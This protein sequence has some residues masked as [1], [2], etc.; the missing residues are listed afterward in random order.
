MRLG[1]RRALAAGLA[2]LL[3]GCGGTRGPAAAA[4][5]TTGRRARVPSPKVASQ[6]LLSDEILWDLGP[7]VR[8]HVVAV[9]ALADDP[10]YADRPGLWPP[11][12]PRV[13]TGSEALLGLG[14]EVAVV[15]SFT[16]PEVRERLTHLGVELL[17]L[18]PL[19]GIDAYR[20][21][22]ARIAERLDA[23]E[24]GRALVARF[25][26]A[27]ARHA[28]PGGT[29]GPRILSYA[30]GVVA[31]SGT[32]FHEVAV[33]TGW[34]NAAAEARIAGHAKVDPERIVAWDPDAVVVPCGQDCD[35][36]VAAFSAIPG[37]SALSAVRSGRVAA[38]E[39]AVLH[40]TGF[41]LTVLAARLARLRDGSDGG[42]RP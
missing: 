4:G 7:D 19:T 5:A 6:T 39:D 31:G 14:T 21:S 25:D 2:L 22:V 11:E 18:P 41:G 40:A 34:R 9:S 10:R 27:L 32:T 8:A 13:R 3:A 28:R 37:F 24:A 38:V 16:A 15:A 1:R 20:T 12:V 33:H 23:A 35:G 29:D 26:A 30:G 36:A 17:V 42:A